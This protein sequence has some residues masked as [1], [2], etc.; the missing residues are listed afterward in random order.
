MI[1]EGTVSF[2]GD[3][4]K[5]RT[6]PSLAVARIVA[7]QHDLEPD[8]SSDDTPILEFTLCGRTIRDEGGLLPGKR[9]NKYR[10]GQTM[11]IL[12]YPDHPEEF[13]A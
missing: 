13:V 9:N 6:A 11:D 12:Y 2:V 1:L 8:G 4:R 5:K 3:L 7:I 10:V